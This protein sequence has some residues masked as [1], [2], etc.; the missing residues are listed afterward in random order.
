MEFV[1][2]GDSFEQDEY[3]GQAPADYSGEETHARGADADTRDRDAPAADT[4][5]GG[6]RKVWIGGLPYDLSD[7][8]LRVLTDPYGSLSDV[9]IKKG[10][11][12]LV[13][14]G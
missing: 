4:A 11:A 9:Q 1:D 8:G 3:E 10:F 14:A 7:A 2:N 6:R 5:S 13:S 12:F